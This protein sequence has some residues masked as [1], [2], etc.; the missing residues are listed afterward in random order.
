E[1]QAADAA[2]RTGA[3]RRFDDVN[4]SH[5]FGLRRERHGHPRA[6]E[7]VWSHM[8]R[9]ARHIVIKNLETFDRDSLS[10]TD[11]CG[12]AELCVHQRNVDSVSAS[13][14]VRVRAQG[15]TWIGGASQQDCRELDAMDG[16]APFQLALDLYSNRSHAGP[17]DLHRS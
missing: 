12:M 1:S 2:G 13:L 7:R 14:L 17:R 15:K 6:N 11:L 10:E 5:D 16:T 3:F 8:D 4:S 9:G